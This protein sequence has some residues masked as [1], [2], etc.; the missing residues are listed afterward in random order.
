MKKHKSAILLL[1]EY[2]QLLESEVKVI[3]AND[4]NYY[5][6]NHQGKLP[7]LKEKIKGLDFAI[8]ILETD[9]L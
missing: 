5:A 6:L 2:K 1:K 4:G 7:I 3:E 8:E 9:N